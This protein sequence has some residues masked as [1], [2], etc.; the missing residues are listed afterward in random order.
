MP[1]AAMTEKWDFWIDRGGTFTDVIG[2]DPRGGLHP[3]KLLSEN[4]EAYADAAIQGIRDLLGMKSGAPVPPGLVGDIKMGTTVATN[5]LLER[6][7]DR[8][9]LLTTKGFRDALRIAYQARLDIFAKEIILPERSTSGSSRSTSACGPMAASNVAR[10]CCLPLGHRAGEGRWH[11]RGGHRLHAC[12]E[13]PR[14][15]EGG[16]KS[17][18]QARLRPGLGQP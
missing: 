14:P 7:G 15:R 1:G 17:L 8:V 16:G 13:V 4:P 11:R 3:R 6:K 18:P 12:L 9:L 10:Y 5:A 2:R